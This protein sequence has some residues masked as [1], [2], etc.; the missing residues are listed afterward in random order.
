MMPITPSVRP[1]LASP[2]GAVPSMNCAATPSTAITRPM[3]RATTPR[4]S[5]VEKN[6]LSAATQRMA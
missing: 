1:H 4:A 3:R 5:L 2:V 6:I